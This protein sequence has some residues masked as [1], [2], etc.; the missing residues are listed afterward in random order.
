M[1]GYPHQQQAGERP[2]EPEPNQDHEDHQNHGP[3]S[4]RVAGFSERALWSTVVEILQI[5]SSTLVFLVLA[6]VFTTETYGVMSGSMGAVAPALGLSN[7]GTHVLLTRR[8]AR[9]HDL[10]AA[11]NRALTIGFAGPAFAT[12]VLLALHPVL[13]PGGNVPWSV[14]ALFAVAGLPFFWLSEMVA[15]LPIG[16]GDLRTVALIRL[17]TLGCRIVALGWFLW[18]SDGSLLEWAA[19]HATSLAVASVVAVTFVGR[20]YGLRPGRPSAVAA[21]VKQGVPFSMS[22]ATESV[23]DGA[24]RVLLVRYGLDGDA[25]LYGLGGRITQF[26]YAPIKILLRSRDAELHRAG[27]RGPAAA[28]RVARSMFLPG[29]GL[30]CAAAAALWLGAPLVPIVFGSTWDEAVPVIRLLA[31]LPAIRSVEYLVGNTITA[32]DRQPW[33]FGATAMAAVLNVVLNVIYLPGGTWRTAVVTTLI[34]EVVLIALLL[35]VVW[36]W[37]RRE[38]IAASHR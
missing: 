13:F 24:D 15:F 37:L 22:S 8:A 2:V 14:F 33:R 4:G 35:G 6:Q 29:L 12:V 25:G 16:L 36:L 11:W 31:F 23:F 1:K 7:L 21:D 28:V 18:L 17:T 38:S 32:F 19:A 9:G 26:G 3:R 30:G 34:S 20:R 5:C 10:A 27:G